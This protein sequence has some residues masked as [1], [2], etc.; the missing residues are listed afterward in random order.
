[1]YFFFNRFTSVVSVAPS[2][3]NVLMMCSQISLRGPTR[4]LIAHLAL[5][6]AL[7]ELQFGLIEMRRDHGLFIA[8]GVRLQVHAL[9]FFPFF[10][11]SD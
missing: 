7:G 5:S 4:V 9:F 10:V 11:A 8:G 2:T 3:I 1:M 6:G